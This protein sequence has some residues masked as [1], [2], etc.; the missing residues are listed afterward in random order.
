MISKDNYNKKRSR[1]QKIDSRFG[2][3]VNGLKPYKLLQNAGLST[4]SLQQSF[5]NLCNRL[6]LSK[7]GKRISKL[8]FIAHADSEIKKMVLLPFKN[9]NWHNPEKSV[10]KRLP[11]EFY[12][13]F[14]L[15]P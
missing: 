9:G 10:A 2:V 13:Y 15:K 12:I 14:Y 6:Y 1:F 7:F 11:I 8:C 5:L 4:S 3:I